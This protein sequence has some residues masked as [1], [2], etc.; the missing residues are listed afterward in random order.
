M[1]GTVGVSAS[2]TDLAT[3]AAQNRWRCQ[4]QILMLSKRLRQLR[5]RLRTPISPCAS[6]FAR[7]LAA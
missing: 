3:R 1:R 4:S 5:R 2:C 7:T 6:F